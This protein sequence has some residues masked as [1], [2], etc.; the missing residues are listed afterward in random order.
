M[1]LIVALALGLLV[2]TVISVAGYRTRTLTRD[3][4]IAAVVV[5]TLVFGCGGLRWAVV[6]VA[7][8]ILSSALSRVGKRR[9][10]AAERLAEKSS[11]R[12]AVQV[13]ANGGVAAL[14][15]LANPLSGSNLLFPA[16]LG[17]LAAA[18]ADTW[19]TEI[20]GLSRQLPRSIITGKIVEPGASGGVTL[21]GLLAAAIGGLS[22]GVIGGISS[23]HTFR[24][25]VLGLIAGL[26]GSVFDSLL[27]ASVQLTYRCPT[28]GTFTERTIHD[29]GTA[30]V[31]AHGLAYL[32]NDSVNGLTTIFGAACGAI[33][34][35]L[36]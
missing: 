9:K 36:L 5:G 22:V 2:A 30:T 17:T 28:C 32:N 8:F 24:L 18:T 13:L 34:F 10:Q 14:L 20:G 26:S 23:V 21:L 16:F 7:F 11:R 6:M 4:A 12:D 29:C 1:T 15:A 33:L 31:P 27:G 25:A 3:G 35:A 19:S